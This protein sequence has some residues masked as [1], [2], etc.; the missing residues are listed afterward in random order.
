M[1]AF[2]NLTDMAKTLKRS[3]AQVMELIERGKIPN[4]CYCYPADYEDG[5]SIAFF[6]EKVLEH[7]KPRKPA[8]KK[9]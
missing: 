7:I 3:P 6:K 1:P 9:K 4:D 2:T 5:H 8:K